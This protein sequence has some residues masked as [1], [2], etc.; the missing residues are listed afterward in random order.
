M[1]GYLSLTLHINHQTMSGKSYI[2]RLSPY[3]LWDMDM[4]KVDMDTCPSQIIQRVLEYGTL[5]DWRLIHKYYG[6]D[7]IVEEC[8]KMRSLDKVALSFICCK[9]N[10]NKEDYRCYRTRQS[11]PTLWNS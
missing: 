11:N 9:S 2:Q 6:L 5:E 7:K 10:T 3:L 8:K 4:E 1:F